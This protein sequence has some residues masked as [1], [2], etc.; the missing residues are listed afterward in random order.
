V[1]VANQAVKDNHKDDLPEYLPAP[2]RAVP[3][4]VLLVGSIFFVGVIVAIG[5]AMALTKNK[6]NEPVQATNPE[7][8]AEP[9]WF[10][11]PYATTIGNV[12]VSVNRP[13]LNDFVPDGPLL[14]VDVSVYNAD[15]TK[16]LDYKRWCRH[17]PLRLF[18]NF[19]NSYSRSVFSGEGVDTSEHLT[20]YSDRPVS[21]RIHFARPVPAAIT[22]FLE[23]DCSAVGQP[24]KLRLKCDVQKMKDA[25]AAEEKDDKARE[26]ERAKGKKKKGP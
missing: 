25:Q 19:G 5:A 9:E 1:S 4:W 21:E 23:L 7:K 14:A 22:L 12:R 13:F 17:A 24:G 11:L 6:P 16:T 10:D 8:Q 20:V 26:N 3:A 18:D 2:R 15:Q